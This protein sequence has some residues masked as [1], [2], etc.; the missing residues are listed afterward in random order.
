[1]VGCVYNKAAN[2]TCSR[3]VSRT[4]AISAISEMEFFAAI[5]NWGVLRIVKFSSYV[6]VSE[7]K[8]RKLLDILVHFC[9]FSSIYV[10]VFSQKGLS[11]SEVKIVEEAEGLR[12]S[13]F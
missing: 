7:N 5:V 4:T 1:M 9:I 10:S 6:Q 8:S 2:G 3:D 11:N 12:S 13:C